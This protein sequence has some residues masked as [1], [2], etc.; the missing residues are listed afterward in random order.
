MWL[1]LSKVG[2]RQLS[3]VENFFNKRRRSFCQ[4]Q[5]EGK[6][7]RGVQ[8]IVRLLRLKAERPVLGNLGVYLRIL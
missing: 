7:E 5:V 8:E 2:R 6:S 3:N 1:A 4:R